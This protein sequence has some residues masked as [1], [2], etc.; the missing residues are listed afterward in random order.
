MTAEGAAVLGERLGNPTVP[1]AARM[2]TVFALKNIGTV[3]AIDALSSGFRD[4]S[5]LLKHEI[6]YVMGQ[7]QNPYAIPILKARLADTSEDPMVRHEAAEALGAIGGEECQRILE[8]Y[9]VD[10]CLEVRET[11]EIA[12]DRIRYTQ[13]SGN[14]E[15]HGTFQSVD[16]A[17]PKEGSQQSVEELR[18]TLLDQSLPLF[19]RY[20]ALFALRNRNTDDAAVA[21]AD[22]FIDESALFRHELAYVLGQ[23]QCPA[24]VKQLGAVMARENEHY[25]VRHEAA[26]ALGSI[27]T[28]ECNDILD[29]YRGDKQPPV[30]ESVEV[31]LDISDYNQSSDFQYADPM[32]TTATSQN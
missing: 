23:M 20:R 12:L 21:I 6:A 26:E 1:I 19:E 25:M 32:P 17:P 8:E 22:A 27:A 15:K 10:P 2:R 24:V 11:C 29:K 14:F 30:R 4:N 28:P 13:E 16:P 9:A 31:A 7:I 3:D 18:A 5:A